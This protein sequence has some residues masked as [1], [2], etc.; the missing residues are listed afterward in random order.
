MYHNLPNAYV[1]GAANMT[2][3]P[4]PLVKTGVRRSFIAGVVG[5]AGYIFNETDKQ[6]GAILDSDPPPSTYKQTKALLGWG[7]TAIGFIGLAAF[8]GVP[9][10]GAA[11]LYVGVGYAALSIG[12]GLHDMAREV[13]DAYS[14]NRKVNPTTMGEAVGDTVGGALGLGAFAAL[15]R[16]AKN[17]SVREWGLEHATGILAML[18]VP[19]VSSK[20]GDAAEHVI[21]EKQKKDLERPR[22]AP[23]ST[24][25]ADSQPSTAPQKYAAL[26][27]GTTPAEETIKQDKKTTEKT[28]KKIQTALNTTQ[29]RGNNLSLTI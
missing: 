13:A 16:V 15:V 17:K 20:A 18:S 9:A 27:T 1:R 21:H 3:I 10:V 5:L 25:T 4:Y 29:Q 22:P 7:A 28:I 26:Q 6:T 12:F 2:R 11:A 23:A 8:V 14:E 19:L 24:F